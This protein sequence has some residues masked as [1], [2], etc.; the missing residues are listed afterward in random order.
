MTF[1]GLIY[2]CIKSSYRCIFW[3]ICVKSGSIYV[4][5]QFLGDLGRW[6]ARP[7]PVLLLVFGRGKSG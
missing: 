2:W 4:Y 3:V 5:V 6:G 1:T 7:Q